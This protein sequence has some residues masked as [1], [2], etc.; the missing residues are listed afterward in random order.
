M[1]LLSLHRR[2]GLSL[3]LVCL[4]M[5]SAGAQDVT[6]LVDHH[7]ADN[8]GVK[9]HY[10]TM[11][12][13]PLIVMIHGFPDFWYTWRYQM[14]GLAKDY[15]VAA[16][17]TRGYNLSDKPV[18]V[19]N[20]ALETLVSD[21]VAVIEAEGESSATVVGHDWGG[22]IAW[23]TAA[24]RPDVTDRL[25]ILN[26]PHPAALNRELATMGQQHTNSIY[27]RNFQQ[28]DSHENLTAERLAGSL[29][30]GD[31]ELYARYFEAFSRSSFDAM[32][33]YYRASYPRE[34]YTSGPFTELPEVQAPV[35][36]FHG[37][38]D[39]AL[40]PEG[41]NNTWDY[42]AADWTLMT[43]PG[44][45]HWPHHAKPQVVTDMMKAWLSLH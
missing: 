11:G 26:L 19:E 15:R 29:S 28:P 30:G 7:Y 45:S 23:A 31:E 10:V 27:A 40:L 33:N 16:L 32:M 2:L 22:G 13:G 9:I 34:P 8:D 43:I 35:L 1:N 17:D 3:A 44:V 41:L 39:T 20:Y 14:P 24:M 12:E 25:I 36:Q 4:F 38:L 5:K 18:G 6:E 21:V 37:L 42:L